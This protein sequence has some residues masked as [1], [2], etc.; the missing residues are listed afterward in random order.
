MK[1]GNYGPFFSFLGYPLEYNIHV[2]LPFLCLMFKRS[3]VMKT[4]EIMFESSGRISD[5][6]RP[7][8]WVTEMERN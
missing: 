2:K 5:S 6:H 3:V 7:H 8:E 1:T 4:H